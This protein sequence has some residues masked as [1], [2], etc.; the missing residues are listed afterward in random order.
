MLKK[1]QLKLA[2]AYE[3]CVA[4]EKVA[5]MLVH[6]ALGREHYR[7][8]GCETGDIPTWDDLVIEH[9]DQTLE[10]IQIKRNFTKFDDHACDRNSDPVNKGKADERLRD[11]SPLDE[12]MASLAE[13]GR[14]HD[15]AASITKKKFSIE[16]PSLEIQIKK[17]I[18]VRHFYDFVRSITP[19]T[20]A[21]SLREIQNTHSPT[22]DIFKWLNTWCGYDDWEHILKI[23]RHLKVT[24]VG[25]ES[26]IES[27]TEHSLT[28]FFSDV[29]S[30]RKKINDFITENSTISSKITPRPLLGK[31]RSFW[32]P[33]F[34]LWTEYIKKDLIWD[35]SGICDPDFDQIERAQKVVE[36]MW[37]Q[38][39]LSSIKIT[40]NAQ[41]DEILSSALKRMVIHLQGNST[42][43]IKDFEVWLER[44]LKFIGGTLGS[45]ED[46]V[47]NLPITELTPH[48][49]PTDFRPITTSG[50]ADSEGALLDEQ[51]DSMTWD[52]VNTKLSNKILVIPTGTLRD[53]IEQRWMDWKAKL[54]KNPALS[55]DLCRKML[56]PNA[57]GRQIIPSLRHGPKTAHLIAGGL[58]LLLATA[59]AISDADEGWDNVGGNLSM[60]IRA[61]RRWSG[62]AEGSRSVR[63]LDDDGIDILIGREPSKI[64]L[65]SGVENGIT[66][67]LGKNLTEG[68]EYSYSLGE[69][70]RP[71][72][73]T[74]SGVV[75]QAL[76]NGDLAML[77]QNIQSMIQNDA[78]AQQEQ[79]NEISK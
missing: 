14:L 44:A 18:Q 34:L 4:A 27:R 31:L 2:D 46:D 55:Q 7:E 17:E 36:A 5:Q 68:S 30:V 11:L 71:L 51:M 69:G 64:L 10:H 45:H 26:S 38:N 61:L 21:E 24:L 73:I 52:I 43:A 47:E 79:L 32:L 13:W 70:K 56:H 1:L 60:G 19:S 74:R 66:Q 29:V 72:L 15:P 59:V 48:H 37:A 40:C 50:V 39:Q 62:P 3:I 53:A 12:S 8:I 67:T 77:R 78:S 42:A 41:G 57:E 65:L 23:F 76:K 63:N 33:E 6:F 35:V 16:L 54:T 25:V 22:A 9:S 75:K 58:L 49:P 20:T 28:F